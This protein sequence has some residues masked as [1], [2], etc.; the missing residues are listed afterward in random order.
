MP[1]V[2]PMKSSQEQRTAMTVEE[3]QNSVLSMLGHYIEIK[4]IY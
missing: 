4:K 2:R 3:V 1:I